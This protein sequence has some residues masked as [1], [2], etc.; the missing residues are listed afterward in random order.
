MSC[1][2]FV[3]LIL[4]KIFACSSGKLSTEFTEIAKSTSPRLLDMTFFAPCE[5]SL[6][7]AVDWDFF[8][9]KEVLFA[10]SYTGS[11]IHLNAFS[12]I[13][14]K[15]LKNLLFS[16]FYNKFNNLVNKHAPM[17]TISNRK[18]KQF[19][20]PWITKGLHTFIKIKN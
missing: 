12:S 9:Q 20:K 6:S 17:K 8:Y 7:I 16:S 1:S 3:I 2:T 13:L 11:I 15:P 18:A 10:A 5:W 4:R 14:M 19:S